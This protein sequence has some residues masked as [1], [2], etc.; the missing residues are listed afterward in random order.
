[1]RWYFK[2]GPNPPPAEHYRQLY[3]VYLAMCQL[4]DD[5]LG[6]L[7]DYLDRHG[8]RE[9]TV[10]V[11]AS[12]HGDMAGEMGCATKWN[13][14][15]DGMARVP[16][17]VSHPGAGL[18]GGARSGEPVSLTDLAATL[19]ELCGFDP[20]QG[21]EGRSLVDLM[22]GT[23]SRDFA[24]VESGLPGKPMDIDDIEHFPDHRWD[25]PSGDGIPYDPPH[26]WTGRCLTARSRR[27]KLI[28]R[29]GQRLEFY[30]LERDPW[31]TRNAADDEAAQP[32]IRRHLAAIGEYQMKRETNPRGAI[33]VP[34]MDQRYTPGAGPVWNGP[35]HPYPAER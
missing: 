6:R 27:H 33:G 22:A 11:F 8:L 3:R 4:I 10:V 31:E 25:L 29:Q 20:P 14:A 12:D 13:C 5:E 34:W 2:A 17:V 28:Q 19:A 23:G 1:M 21:N 16:L 35:I 18:P 30:D 32:E 9:N 15:Y 26:R 24:F 7:L